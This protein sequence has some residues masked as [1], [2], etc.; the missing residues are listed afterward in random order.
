MTKTRVFGLRLDARQAWAWKR[1]G[2][3]AIRA[4]IAP[5]GIC[6]Q[7]GSNRASHHSR[8]G[9]FCLI[10]QDELDQPNLLPPSQTDL[11]EKQNQDLLLQV[12]HLH[13]KVKSLQSGPPQ[14]QESQLS[15]FGE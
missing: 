13:T 2:Q 9:W 3:H 5:K 4:L 8:N 14:L 6:V 7:C 12:K 11:L 10:C 1:L 15:L